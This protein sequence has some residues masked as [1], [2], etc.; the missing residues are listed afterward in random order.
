MNESLQINREGRLMHIALNRPDRRNALN[1]ELCTAL[2]AALDEA[3]RD[4]AVGAIL[5]TANG[6]SFCAGMDLSEAL[7]HDA[8]N[9]TDVQERIFTAGSTMSKPIV[10]AVHGAALAGG[11]GLVANCHIVLADEGASFG[12]TE[13]RIGLWPFVIFRSV[14]AAIGER[15]AIELAL[16]GQFLGPN[17][18]REYGL[19]H[20]IVEPGS[21]LARA[22]EIAVPLS[23][24]SPTAIQSGLAYVRKARGKNW[25]EAGALAREIREDVFRS[26]DFQEGV[27][28]FQEKRPP[29]WPSLG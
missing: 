12:L 21:L 24:A 9:L 13:I 20:Y 4:P 11:M 18:A 19:V 22:R 26:P 28:A 23:L 14:A 15:R 10:A 2:A 1:V 17:E 25:A 6:K 3:E 16:T 8:S 27:R 29:R 5:L 7:T